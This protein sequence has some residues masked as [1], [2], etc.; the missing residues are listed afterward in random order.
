MFC[1]IFRVEPKWVYS[2]EIRCKAVIHAVLS[3]DEGNIMRVYWRLGIPGWRI[4]ATLGIPIKV[5]VDVCHDQEAGVY[6]AVSDDI[7]LAVEAESLDGLMKEIHSALPEL[8][9]LLHAPVP[10]PKADIRLHD[11]LAMA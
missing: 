1:A 11:N 9:T 2:V 5:K 7:G 8:L 6:F 4:A 3:T 10:S